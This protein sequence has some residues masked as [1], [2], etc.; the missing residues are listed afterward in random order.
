MEK[1]AYLAM[2][3]HARSC[4]L[5]HMD[6]DGCF[7]GNLRFATCEKNI[8][9]AL[10][11]VKAKNKLLTIEEGTFTHWIAQVASPYVNEVIAC[12]NLLLSLHCH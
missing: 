7:K 3:V 10:K 9:G 8:I 2:D 5:G 6:A 1:I 12:D 11:S 4:T